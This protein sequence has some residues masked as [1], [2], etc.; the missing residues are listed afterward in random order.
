M[1]VQQRYKNKNQVKS[2]SKSKIELCCEDPTKI[3]KIKI[4]SNISKKVKSNY[5]L[6]IQQRYEKTKSDQ[7]KI[8]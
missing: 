1:K 6:K 5:V 2:E 4:G 8:Q 7:I 3:Q